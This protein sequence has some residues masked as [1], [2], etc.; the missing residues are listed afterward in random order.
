M[1]QQTPTEDVST[2]SSS[3]QR[4]VNLMMF[5]LDCLMLSFPN[6]VVRQDVRRES[7]DCDAEARKEVG[8]HCAI[9][10]DWV[11]PPRITLGPW[12]K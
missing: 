7:D 11:S 12:I 3:H 10:E 4:Q 6:D 5:V 2:N 1:G 9:R 8:K